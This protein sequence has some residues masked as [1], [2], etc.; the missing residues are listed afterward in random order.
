VDLSNPEIT[1]FSLQLFIVIV[2]KLFF[3][4]SVPTRIGRKKERRFWESKFK[5]S[6]SC[7][8]ASNP[9]YVNVEL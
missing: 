4:P 3:I 2:F 1:A 8:F 9:G 5:Q 6:S 7:Y